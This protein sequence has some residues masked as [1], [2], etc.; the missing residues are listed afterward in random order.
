M[1]H[2]H[3]VDPIK[4]VGEGI[5]M[6]FCK[7]NTRVACRELNFRNVLKIEKIKIKECFEN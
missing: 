6:P 7:L 2:I 4:G 5:F 1:S 3:V